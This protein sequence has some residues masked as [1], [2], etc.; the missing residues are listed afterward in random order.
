MIFIYEYRIYF[1]ESIGKTMYNKKIKNKKKWMKWMKN[2]TSIFSWFKEQLHHPEATFELLKCYEISRIY[3]SIAKDDSKEAVMQFLETAKKYNIE[4]YILAGEVEWAYEMYQQEIIH[5]IEEAS[6]YYPLIK[7]VVLD[8]EP[9]SLEDFP[10]DGQMILRSFAKN[11]QK[12]YL[13]TQSYQLEM[14]VCLPY[15]YDT[16]GYEMEL[17]TII[18]HGLDEVAIMNYYR[19]KELEHMEFE[20]ALSQ[21]YHKK[22]QTIYELQAPD[23]YGLTDKNTYYNYGIQAVYK[24]YKKITEKIPYKEVGLS[25]HEFQSFKELTSKD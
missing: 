11:L 18:A 20:V 10:Q 12:A 15:Y 1:I 19:E 23:K 3:Q 2:N 16:M 25:F 6:L 22:I 4:V 7:G 13:L 21:K 9:H 14:V 17:E 8:I 24:S 5:F